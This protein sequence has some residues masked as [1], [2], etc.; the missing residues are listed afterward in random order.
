MGIGISSLSV[1][2]TDFRI[3]QTILVI[4]SSNDAAPRKEFGPKGKPL[5]FAVLG[6]INENYPNG[7][8]QPKYSNP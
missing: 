6:V 7:V 4:H 8:S 2:L 3:A 1:E 5:K